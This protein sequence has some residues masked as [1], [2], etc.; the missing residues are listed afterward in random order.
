MQRNIHT[1]GTRLGS[2]FMLPESCRNLFFWDFAHR[3]LR[4]PI[5]VGHVTHDLSAAGA[6]TFQSSFNRMLLRCHRCIL[7]SSTRTEVLNSRLIVSRSRHSQ[8]PRSPTEQQ[9][10]QLCASHIDG[11]S[12]VSSPQPSHF[13]S[14]GH[15]NARRDVVVC[16]G[17]MG[18]KN[19][20]LDNVSFILLILFSCLIHQ[21]FQVARVWLSLSPS[22]SIVTYRPLPLDVPWLDVTQFC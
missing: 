3:R 12:C 6:N 7:S 19:R 8:A 17:W 11:F 5:H 13:A 21:F 18:C 22:A 20:H 10:H 2:Y 15:L 16:L 1:E 4:L 14:S 9:P